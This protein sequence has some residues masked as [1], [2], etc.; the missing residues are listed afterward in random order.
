MSGLQISADLELPLD[1]VTET[2]AILAK[3]GAG[4][5]NAAVVIAEQMHHAGLPW[6]AIDPKGDWWGIRSGRDGHGPGL[7]VLVLG[8]QHGDVPLEPT[9][10]RLVADLIVEQRLTSVVDVS[11]MSKADARRFLADLA[12]RLYQANTEPLHVFAEEAHEYIPQRVDAGAARMV[13]AWEK[14]VKWGRTHGLGV[15]LIT[16]RSASLNKDVLTQVETLI[17]LRTTGPQDQAAIR[18]WVDEHENGAAMIAQLRKLGNGE[19]FILSP[20]WLELDEPLRI[21][22]NRRRT[23]DSGATPRAGEKRVTP[24]TLAEVDLAALKEAMAET[25]ERSKAEDP[26]HLRRRI[27]ELERN[28]AAERAKPTPEPL[29][30]RVKVPVLPREL[31]DLLINH[32]DAVT[33]QL[34]RFPDELPTEG[35]RGQPTTRSSAPRATS[36]SD[37]DRAP[38][39][40]PGAGPS[41]H[42]EKNPPAARETRPDAAGGPDIHLRSG[43]HRMVEALGR[44]APLRL[45]KSQWGT[46]ARLKTSGGTWSTYLSDIRRAGLIDESSAGYTLTDAGFD[47][48][49]GRPAPMTAVELQDHYRSILRS[50]AVKMLDALIDAYPNSLTREDLGAAAGIATS[51][52][53]F[54][55]YLS[56]L[57]RNGLA[58]RVDGELVATAILMFGANR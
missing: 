21:R 2:F 44:M 43:A 7:P 58:E 40:A 47:Y 1:A 4:K 9:A 3:R 32:L 13:G 36:T 14:L 42:R 50:G 41:T 33:R 18:A 48:L 52:G 30:E 5:S 17:A 26:K 46:V 49:G 20:Q 28:L 51:G 23:F 55:T 35:K 24:R 37:A 53:T 15:T 19:A 25:I 45:T 54:S 16:Q 56:D 31:A 12:E 8:G 11:L 10:G 38:G 34:M 27:A 22:F 57:V 29:V 39:R 6:V